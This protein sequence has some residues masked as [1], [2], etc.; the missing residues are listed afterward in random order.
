MSKK[1]INHL[2]KRI[3]K[4]NQFWQSTK[5]K[6]SISNKRIMC[7][8]NVSLNRGLFDWKHYKEFQRCNGFYCFIGGGEHLFVFKG[9]S[10]WKSRQSYWTLEKQNRH[11]YIELCKCL[12]S[13]YVRTYQHY[14]SLCTRS[15]TSHALLVYRMV[16]TLCTWHQRTGIWRSWKNYWK[17]APM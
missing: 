2:H 7:C 16:W 8:A 9:C 17:E 10:I 5:K 4:I 12:Q 15:I 1:Y 14:V 3:Q 6:N 13:N 11:K